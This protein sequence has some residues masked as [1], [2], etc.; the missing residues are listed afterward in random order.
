MNIGTGGVGGNVTTDGVAITGCTVRVELT[1]LVAL[2]DVELGEVTCTLNLP[3]QGSLDKV[4]RGDGTVG[5]DTGIVTGFYPSA[6]TFAR[7]CPCPVLRSCRSPQ[8]S[9]QI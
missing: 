6:M 8:K 3:V 2:G 5:N 4:G 7:T 9:M 1:T